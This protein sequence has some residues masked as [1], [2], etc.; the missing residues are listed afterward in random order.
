MNYKYLV[1]FPENDIVVSMEDEH[2]L[3]SMLKAGHALYEDRVKK[4][5]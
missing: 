2:A 4:N 3:D 1:I 5:R